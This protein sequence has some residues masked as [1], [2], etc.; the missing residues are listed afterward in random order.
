MIINE[1][2]VLKCSDQEGRPTYVYTWQINYEV[3]VKF[4]E[5]VNK[6]EIFNDEFYFKIF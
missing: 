6:S 2:N 1:C 5:Q 4:E 3:F